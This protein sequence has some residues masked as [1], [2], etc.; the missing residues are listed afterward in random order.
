MLHA[1]QDTLTHVPSVCKVRCLGGVSWC[2]VI[3]ICEHGSVMQ[4]GAV[5]IHTYTHRDIHARITVSLTRTHTHALCTSTEHTPPLTYRH[6]E[7][8]APVLEQRTCGAF[9]AA[10]ADSTL[11]CSS[12]L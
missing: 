7:S 2:F 1:S 9:A 10:R 6:F 12:E 3:G 4:V 11:A 8:R 5:H